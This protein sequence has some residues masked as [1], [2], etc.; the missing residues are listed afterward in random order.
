MAE[1]KD[2]KSIHFNLARLQNDN[3]EGHTQRQ[4]GREIYEGARQTGR[5]IMQKRGRRVATQRF[6]FDRGVWVEV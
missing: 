1:A 6:D 5:D 4:L 3:K 2:Y